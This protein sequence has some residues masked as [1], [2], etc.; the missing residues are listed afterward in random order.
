[1]REILTISID[2]HL[3]R[4]VEK[5]AGMLHVSKSELVK[6]AIEKYIAHEEL[7][8][9]RETLVPY[10]EKSGCFTDE[11]IFNSVS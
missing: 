2:K 1:M 6:K 8:V 5:A 9:I 11:D 10:G 3:K 7:R 4:K